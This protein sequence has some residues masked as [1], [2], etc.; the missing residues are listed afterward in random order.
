MR[1]AAVLS[2]IVPK[3]EEYRRGKHGRSSFH[4]LQSP[5]S[6]RRRRARPGRSSGAVDPDPAANRS[7]DGAAEPARLRQH[8]LPTAATALRRRRTLWAGSA[9]M[10]LLGG[11]EGVQSVLHPQGP[12]AERIA[13][14]GWIMF[15][16]AAAISFW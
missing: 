13:T 5:R 1:G 12:D 16:G 14:L 6:H 11:C 3:R 4:R 8:G 15:A 10:L 2:V 9:T 7:R